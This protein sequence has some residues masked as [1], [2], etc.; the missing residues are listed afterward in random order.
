MCSCSLNSWHPSLSKRPWNLPPA[1]RRI[2]GPHLCVRFA[3]TIRWPVKP[4]LMDGFHLLI[5]LYVS[6]SLGPPSLGSGHCT[7]CRTA[8][9]HD[10]CVLFYSLGFGLLCGFVSWFM[11]LLNSVVHAAGSMPAGIRVAVFLETRGSCKKDSPRRSFRR[12]D[13][14]FDIHLFMG[15]DDSPSRPPACL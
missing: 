1:R 11:F 12:N 7:G 5:N 10:V 14:T 3:S 15:R 4:G 9:I 6:D 13:P 2:H 8:V